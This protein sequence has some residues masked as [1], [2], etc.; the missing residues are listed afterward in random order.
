MTWWKDFGCATK[1]DLEV[2]IRKLS[3][4]AP[5]TLEPNEF[6]WMKRLLAR[7]YNFEAKGGHTATS[8]EVRW[9]S[10]YGQ[11]PSRCFFLVQPDGASVDISWRIAVTPTGAPSGHSNQRF[12]MRCEVAEQIDKWVRENLSPPLVCGFCGNEITDKT[13]V[14]HAPPDTFAVIA[15]KFEEE[16]GWGGEIVDGSQIGVALFADRDY[17]ERWKNYHEDK[18]KLRW[19]HEKCNIRG[20]SV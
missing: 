16:N 6:G 18:A 5:R 1:K 9:V 8:I 4:V 10:A 12:A 3:E 20:K 17:A 14:D 15:G 11:K 2:W 19:A 13:N 7:H